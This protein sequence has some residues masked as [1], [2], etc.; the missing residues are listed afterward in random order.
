LYANI[1]FSLQTHCSRRH[2]CTCGTEF[3]HH[4]GSGLAYQTTTYRPYFCNRW[5]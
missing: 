2:T 4:L 5:R 1:A 3:L